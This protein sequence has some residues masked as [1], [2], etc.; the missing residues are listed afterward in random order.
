MSATLAVTAALPHPLPQRGT[1]PRFLPG[2]PLVVVAVS[3][4]DEALTPIRAPSARP[5][6]L[7]PG[8]RGGRARHTA[9]NAIRAPRSP[10]AGGASLRP[11]QPRRGGSGGAEAGRRQRRRREVRAAPSRRGSGGGGSGS[12]DS[13][14]IGQGEMAAD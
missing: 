11:S 5:K 14:V 12:A 2:S 13:V 6:R 1:Q 10:L 8:A 3:S 4:A 7:A 9:R